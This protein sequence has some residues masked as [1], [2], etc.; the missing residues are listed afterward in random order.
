VDDLP[1]LKADLSTKSVLYSDPRLLF[2]HIKKN[3]LPPKSIKKHDFG[4]K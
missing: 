3:N 4:E 1:I 2:K